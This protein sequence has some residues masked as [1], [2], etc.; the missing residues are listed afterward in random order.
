MLHRIEQGDIDPSF[1]IT[2]R[3]GLEQAPHGYDAFRKKTDGCIK[4]VMTPGAA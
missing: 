2:H 3:L 1:A 4:V